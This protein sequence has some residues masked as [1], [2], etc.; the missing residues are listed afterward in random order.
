MPISSTEEKVAR[1]IF[2]IAD[3]INWYNHLGEHLKKSDKNTFSTPPTILVKLLHAFIWKILLMFIAELL[4]T[5]KLEGNYNMGITITG[6]IYLHD[7]T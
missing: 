4:V 2:T 6:H 3:S 5:E 1:E 7:S